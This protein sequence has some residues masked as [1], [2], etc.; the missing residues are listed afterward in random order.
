ML[1]STLPKFMKLSSTRSNIS[2]IE[3]RLGL[4]LLAISGEVCHTLPLLR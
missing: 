1:K 3:I 4:R 2:D